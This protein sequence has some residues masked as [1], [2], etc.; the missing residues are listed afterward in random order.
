MSRSLMEEKMVQ[1]HSYITQETEYKITALQ[2]LMHLKK[3][4]K[5]SKQSIIA[6]ALNDYLDYAINKLEGESK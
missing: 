4:E 1:L 6:K 2:A 5:V 3:K